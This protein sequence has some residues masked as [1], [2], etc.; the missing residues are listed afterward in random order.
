MP[1]ET[2]TTGSP[3]KDAPSEGDATADATQHDTSLASF[4]PGPT[5]REA[6]RD[7]EVR[8]KNVLEE[9]SR[10]EMPGEK[11]REK[12]CRPPWG[13][14]AEGVVLCARRVSYH[15]ALPHQFQSPPW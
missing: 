5:P 7:G 9:M 10:E 2:A 8:L 11:M 14:R 15:R 13:L 6:S 1:G 3:N 12:V 4:I